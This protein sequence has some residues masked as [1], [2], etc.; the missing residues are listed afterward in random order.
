MRHM[1]SCAKLVPHAT[2][3]RA[4]LYDKLCSFCDRRTAA[5]QQTQHFCFVQKL[6]LLGVA[7][8]QLD[9]NLGATFL[10]LPYIANP[11]IKKTLAACQPCQGRRS[12][13]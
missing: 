5:R 11:T 3:G 10:V 7:W 2:C 8:L 1:L 4:A 12:S 9:R 6:R 13:R